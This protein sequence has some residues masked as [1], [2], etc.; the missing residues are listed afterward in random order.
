MRV[1]EVSSFYSRLCMRFFQG[2]IFVVDS[3][4]RERAQEAAE[5]LQK[6]VSETHPNI[7]IFKPLCSWPLC[8]HTLHSVNF[9]VRFKRD[10]VLYTTAICDQLICLYYLLISL[11]VKV[12]I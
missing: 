2:L 5:E 7:I 6:M 12:I 9:P 11:G 1:T 8:V 3:N 4:D 10:P